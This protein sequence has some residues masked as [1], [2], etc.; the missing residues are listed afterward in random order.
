MF[1]FV[2]PPVWAERSAK[3]CIAALHVCSLENLTSEGAL[4][5]TSQA[6]AVMHYEISPK[7][8]TSQ[9]KEAQ[10]LTENNFFFF[11]FFFSKMQPM[12]EQQQLDSASALPVKT[13]ENQCAH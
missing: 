12:I 1:W 13:T 11:F 10:N 3:P 7:H 5:E 4:A 2:F 8:Y 9:L 6:T